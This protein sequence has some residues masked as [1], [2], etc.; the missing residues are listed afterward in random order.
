[1]KILINLTLIGMM[2]AVVVGCTAPNALS[3]QTSADGS[4]AIKTVSNNPKLTTQVM[5]ERIY[6]YGFS[7]FEMGYAAAYSWILFVIIFL[8]T[9][10]QLKLQ[11]RWVHYES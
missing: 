8:L 5:V 4:Y 10:L 3:T 7:Y 6:T 9:L 2:S 11:K 1:M